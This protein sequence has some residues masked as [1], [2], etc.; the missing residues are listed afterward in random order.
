MVLRIP[1]SSITSVAVHGKRKRVA[2]VKRTNKA[3]R[4]VTACWIVVEAGGAS[5]VKYEA[6]RY[7]DV[8]D[9]AIWQ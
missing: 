2:A 4:G 7:E 5:G 8:A 6:Y 1:P 9:T 3:S